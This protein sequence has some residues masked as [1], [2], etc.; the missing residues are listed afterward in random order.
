MNNNTQKITQGAMIIAIF[1]ALLLLNRQTGGLFEDIFL[2][3]YPIPMVA[4]AALYGWK[5]SLPVFVC[6][7]MISF[8]C[9]TF[10]NIFYAISQAFIG[11]VFGTR[12]NHRRNPTSTMLLVMVLSAIAT[13]LSTVV[14]AAISGYN[15]T[16]D[17]LEMKSVFEKTMESTGAEIPENLFSVSFFTRMFIISMAISGL[18][19]GFIVYEISLLILRR[20]RFPVQK[21][22][23]VFEFMPPVWSG[24]AALGCLVL[25]YYT[26]ASPLPDDNL[27][28]VCQCIGVLGV[29]YLMCFGILA[30]TLGF[31]I[32]MPQ[33]RVLPAV[34]AVL[35]FF[36]MSLVVA[37]AGFMYIST[38][39]HRALLDRWHETVNRRQNTKRLP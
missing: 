29:F 2:F 32:L 33:A 20:L 9:T 4:Y 11:M 22:T 15:I 38:G 19:Q 26:F 7:C 34:L 28:S 31:K 3:I 25:Y 8:L 14:L 10:T 1:G 18:L 36:I 30:V 27:Q 6:M 39:F 13:V 23:P 24:Y 17:I 37:I 16:D 35:L 21:P 5:S 12:L